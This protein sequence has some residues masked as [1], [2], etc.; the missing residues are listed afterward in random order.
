M[1]K[2]TFRNESANK[3]ERKREAIRFEHE[4]RQSAKS[5][6]EDEREVKLE[7]LRQSNIPRG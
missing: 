1:T 3:R 7:G 2:R 5:V 4:K 6:I